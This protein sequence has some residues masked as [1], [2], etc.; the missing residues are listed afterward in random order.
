MWFV[1]FKLKHYYLLIVFCQLLS[2]NLQSISLFLLSRYQNYIMYLCF[3]KSI[4]I[5]SNISSLF[6]K[7]L[8]YISQVKKQITHHNYKFFAIYTGNIPLINLLILL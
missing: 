6:V 1:S 2:F 7:Q 8:N 4:Y 5:K 3:I